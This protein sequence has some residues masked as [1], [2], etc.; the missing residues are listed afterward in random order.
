[1]KNRWSA[2]ALSPVI[3]S[4]SRFALPTAA[5][6]SFQKLTLKNSRSSNSSAHRFRWSPSGWM[7]FSVNKRDP[8][9]RT[10]KSRFL[11][12]NS[13]KLKFITPGFCGSNQIKTLCVFASSAAAGV[14]FAPAGT[15]MRRF[16]RM[17]R[18]TSFSVMSFS[19]GC[20]VVKADN[21]RMRT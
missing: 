13:D 21:P 15:L 1:M 4:P 12:K 6:P 9:P 16:S 17:A 11:G 8:I 14:T 3:C 20:I 5:F 2:S 7:L 10:Y 19:G 18:R